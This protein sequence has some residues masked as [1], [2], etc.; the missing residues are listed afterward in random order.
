M[1]IKRYIGDPV[2]LNI[3][4][5]DSS[6]QIVPDLSVFN[7][8]TLWIEDYRG[9]KKYKEWSVST[10]TAEIDPADTLSIIINKDDFK[11]AN[12]ETVRLMVRPK[13]AD[14]NFVGGFKYST[15]GYNLF[16]LLKN[17]KSYE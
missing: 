13:I 12:I 14:D 9:N 5:K 15:T 2:K 11:T 10:G 16:E 17:A 1:T 4:L 3:K 6:G 7:D 8:I